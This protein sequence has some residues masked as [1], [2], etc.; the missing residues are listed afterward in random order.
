MTNFKMFHYICCLIIQTQ[1]K[2]YKF[3]NLLRTPFNCIVLPKL[4]NK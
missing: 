3:L 4:N 1:D 2:L